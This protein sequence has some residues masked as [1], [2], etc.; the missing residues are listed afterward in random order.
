LASWNA[1]KP[2]VVKRATSKNA[3]AFVHQKREEELGRV[4]TGDLLPFNVVFAILSSFK[5][6][7]KLR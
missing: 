6:S 1:T 7:E 4:R 2:E 5:A 3:A